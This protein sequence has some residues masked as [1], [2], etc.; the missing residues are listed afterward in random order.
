MLRKSSKSTCQSFTRLYI[1]NFQI[2]QNWKSEMG[3]SSRTR[4]QKYNQESSISKPRWCHWSFFYGNNLS[5]TIYC[6]TETLS[7]ALQVEVILAVESQ[8]TAN[9]ALETLERMRSQE[10]S[11]AFFDTVKSKVEK[12]DFIEEPSLHQKKRIP[13]YRTLEQYFHVQGR[14]VPCS[15]KIFFVSS[16]PCMWEF[17]T[18]LRWS[19]WS[20]YFSYQRETQPWFL[21]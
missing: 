4:K 1:Y 2:L 10:N 17:S 14:H 20:D 21:T 11:N 13:N 8:K 16:I 12:I 7:K 18:N 5:L 6:I 9:L 15:I 3:V 19:P